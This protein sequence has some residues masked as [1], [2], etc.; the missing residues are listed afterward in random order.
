VV[1]VK[2]TGVRLH[3][4]DGTVLNCELAD[5]GVDD[6]GMHNWEIANAVYR[7]G[8]NIT[9]EMLPPRTGIG[10]KAIPGMTGMEMEWSDEP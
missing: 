1:P 10:F 7:P 9:I 3:R 5:K 8:D 4:A 6:K 2:P